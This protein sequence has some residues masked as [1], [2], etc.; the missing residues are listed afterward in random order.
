MILQ[1]DNPHPSGP[2]SGATLVLP[3]YTFTNLTSHI[4]T[5]SA[6]HQQ[7]LSSSSEDSKQH[8]VANQTGDNMSTTSRDNV[9]P[10]GDQGKDIKFFLLSYQLFITH[11]FFFFII[12]SSLVNIF[13]SSHHSSIFS[14]PP[15]HHSSVSSSDCYTRI[16]PHGEG[17]KNEKKK[18]RDSDD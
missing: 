16:P 3:H 2:D 4:M 14:F 17:F 13:S 9:S 8:G 12:K 5:Y 10:N 11:Q 6:R 7:E 15:S 18:N 1:M